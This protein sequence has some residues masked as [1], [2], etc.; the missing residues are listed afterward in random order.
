MLLN[1]ELEVTLS[2]FCRLCG[3]QAERVLRWVDEGLVEPLGTEGSEWRFRATQVV[4][5]RT[6][7]RLQRD[8]EIPEA[9]LALVMDMLDEIRELRARVRALERRIPG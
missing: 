6:A 4:R 2:E 7:R 8:F 9:S 5:V 1:E 3:M